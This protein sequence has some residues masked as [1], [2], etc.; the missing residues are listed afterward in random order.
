MKIYRYQYL[1][2]NGSCSNP[3]AWEV[4]LYGYGII[5][6]LDLTITISYQENMTFKVW[7]KLLQLHDQSYFSSKIKTKVCM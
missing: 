1:F 5:T 2:F 3:A 7:E 4:V 6:K